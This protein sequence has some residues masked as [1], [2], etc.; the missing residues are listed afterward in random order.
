MITNI[1]YGF[2]FYSDG[3]FSESISKKSQTLIVLPPKENINVIGGLLRNDCKFRGS[4]ECK[5]TP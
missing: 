1:L 5:K 3:Q 2:H 4:V